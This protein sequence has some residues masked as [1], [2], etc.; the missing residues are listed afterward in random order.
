MQYSCRRK[1]QPI[2]ELSHEECTFELALIGDITYFLNESTFKLQREGINSVWYTFRHQHAFEINWDWFINKSKH[3]S[4]IYLV[5]GVQSSQN[6]ARKEVS[7]N[8]RITQG[9][10]FVKSLWLPFTIKGKSSFFRTLS[11]NTLKMPQESLQ[12]E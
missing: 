7:K 1:G 2:P 3:I 4:Y 12:L 10:I 5:V 11:Q 9:W 6:M 8:Y